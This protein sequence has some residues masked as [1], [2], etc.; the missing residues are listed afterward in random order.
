MPGPTRLHVAG[1]TM[2]LSRYPVGTTI[3]NQ[4]YQRAR[5][6]SASR[7]F[8]FINQSLQNSAVLSLCDLAHKILEK[9]YDS[10]FPPLIRGTLSNL[11]TPQQEVSGVGATQAQI[12]LS[13]EE[14][15]GHISHLTVN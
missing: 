7:A 3:P 5:P 14:P 12:D 15:V 8:F 10:Y 2:G 9:F 6:R 1:V 13:V 4:C 11:R